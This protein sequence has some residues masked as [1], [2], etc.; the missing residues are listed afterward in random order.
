MAVEPHDGSSLPD[1]LVEN[2]PLS[3]DPVAQGDDHLRLLKIV[4]KNFYTQY[5][6]AGTSFDSRLDNLE[7][8]A[9]I[10]DAATL[11]GQNALFFQNA[12]NMAFGILPAARL[13]GTYGI[14]ITGNAA[15]ATNATNAANAANATYATSA[16]DAATLGGQTL[17]QLATNYGV[18]VSLSDLSETGV[19]SLTWVTLLTKTLSAALPSMRAMLSEL[20]FTTRAYEGGSFSHSV[21]GAVRLVCQPSGKVIHPE[22]PAVAV[23]ECEA[24]GFTAGLLAVSNFYFQLHTGAGPFTK[25]W[26]YDLSG[27]VP[28]GTTSIELQVQRSYT[29]HAGLGGGVYAKVWKGRLT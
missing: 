20:S 7:L 6:A 21:L 10:G 5:L 27:L 2:N 14:N 25:T 12:D 1:V 11:G 18:D 19:G 15:T 24:A 29:T 16:G 26:A 4:V 3:D 13:S 22:M 8:F 28:A 23:E 17:A 9:S